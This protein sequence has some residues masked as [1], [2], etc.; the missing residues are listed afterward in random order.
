MISLHTLSPSDN[1][2]LWYSSAVP[3]SDMFKAIDILADTLCDS[4]HFNVMG[5]D[6]KNEPHG[7][8]WGSGAKN[9]FR[10]GATE[11]GNRMLKACPQWITFIEGVNRAHVVQAPGGAISYYDWFGGGLQD[12]GDAPLELDIDN[13]VIY[14]P[15]Y[16]NPAVYPQLFLYESGKLGAGGL[17]NNFVEL[18]DTELKRRVDVTAEHMFGYLRNRKKEAIVL[19][20]FAGLHTKDKHPLKTIQRINDAC[21]QFIKEPGYAGGFMWSLNP[22]S[23]YDF[24]PSDTRGR[25]VEGLLN[26]DWHSVNQKFLDAMSPLDS[27]QDL[28][29]LPCFPK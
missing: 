9:D 6:L 28:R 11:L 5:L 18:S 13:K 26:Q 4:E 14:A 22:E 19:G 23:G 25:F 7:A 2:D 10:I 27:M 24:N 20:E 1:G 21:V 3:V 29:M 15:H 16:Y 8:T 17:I 12:V